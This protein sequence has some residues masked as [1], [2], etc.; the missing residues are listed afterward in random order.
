MTKK[1]ELIPT[2]CPSCGTKLEVVGIHLCC[3]NKKCPERNVLL[4]L[5]W[6]TNCNIE[7]FAE[8][9]VRTLY[10]A[11]KIKSVKDLYNLSEKSFDGI[12][13]F[14][15]KKIE[16]ALSEIERTKVMTLSSFIDKLSIEGVGEKFVNKYGIKTVNDFLTYDNSDG[17]AYGKNIV[18]YVKENRDYINDLLSVVT[19]KEPVQAA[20]VKAGA[21]H[22]AMTGSGPDKRD[23]LIQRISEM[24]DIFDDGVRKT[25]NIL[26]CE[27]KGSGSSKL[28]KAEK[29]GVTIMNYNEY[30]K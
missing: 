29:M 5:H 20:P 28:V 14:G 19:I 6:V 9:S 8:S 2:H 18:E 3:L 22:I 13:G 15:S 1:N 25:T 26:L 7:G 27:D 21:R 12:E 11:G 10:N 23:N 17:S 24:G 4:I 16:N 30:F